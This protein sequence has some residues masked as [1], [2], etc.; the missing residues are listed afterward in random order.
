MLPNKLKVAGIDYQIQEVEEIDDDPS[1]MGCYIY[2]KSIIKIKSNMSGDKK[3]QTL[4]HEMLHACFNEAGFDEQDE[5]VVNR[6]G[7]VLYQV[8]KDNQLSF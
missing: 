6:V 2:A 5:D 1:M 3:E 8:L 7:I 4:V